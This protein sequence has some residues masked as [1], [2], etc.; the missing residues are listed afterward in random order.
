MTTETKAEENKPETAL[1]YYDEEN[2]RSETSANENARAE[3]RMSLNS[4]EMM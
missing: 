3:Y 1:S 4:Y 2:S